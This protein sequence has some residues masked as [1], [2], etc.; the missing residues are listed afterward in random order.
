M[1]RNER[2]SSGQ[3]VKSKKLAGPKCSVKASLLGLLVSATLNESISIN[4][5]LSE[6]AI[7]HIVRAI[8]FGKRQTC[9]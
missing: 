5:H 1:A 7:S 3:Q 4:I 8:R 6:A 2:S 9:F